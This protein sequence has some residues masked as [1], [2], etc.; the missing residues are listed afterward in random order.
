[1]PPYRASLP[2]QMD[3]KKIAFPMARPLIHSLN[4]F[5]SGK[6]EEETFLLNS[7]RLKP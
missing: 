3:Q 2:P 4:E 7:A 5:N 1:M 6:L